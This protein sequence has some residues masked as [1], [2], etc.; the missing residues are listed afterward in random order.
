MA[1]L[2]KTLSKST[3]GDAVA[4]ATQALKGMMG[5]AEELVQ[6]MEKEVELIEQRKIAEHAQLLKRKQRLAVD[7]RASVKA[8]STQPEI[9]KQI[10]ADLRAKAKIAVQK[11]TEVSD[12]NARILR[13][14]I[15]ALQRL[16]QSIVAIVKEEVL[17]KGSYGSHGAIKSMMGSYSPICKP[18]TVSRTA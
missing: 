17:P 16:I 2:T 12:R 14:A 11:L 5:M 1:L 18:V 4:V 13:A 7:Y 10:P 8:L 6:L 3:G 15:T 9:L